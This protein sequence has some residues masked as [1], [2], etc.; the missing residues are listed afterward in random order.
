MNGIDINK[1][2]DMINYAEDTLSM[3]KNKNKKK[4]KQKRIVKALERAYAL[5]NKKVYTQIEIDKTTRLLW[6]SL[7]NNISVFAWILVGLI[8]LGVT[9]FTGEKIYSFIKTSVIS[10]NKIH[11][12]TDELYKLITINYEETNVVDLKGL[13]G[14]K[15]ELLE[16]IGKFSLK[17]DSS[18]LPKEFD[19]IVNYTVVIKKQSATLDEKYIKYQIKYEDFNGNMTTTPIGKLSDLKKNK[20]G[21]LILI[22]GKQK[23]DAT[24]NFE[25]TM[26]VDYDIPNQEQGKNYKFLFDVETTLD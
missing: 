1:L 19:Y 22:S 15:K 20:K 16:P 8:L 24:T 11:E 13:V 10:K 6:R 25:V 9:T 12:M 7:Q 5:L 23:K 14:T 4:R 26:W 17:N 21:D 18:K 2:N 3:L